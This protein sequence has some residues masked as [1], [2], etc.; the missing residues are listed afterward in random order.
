MGLGTVLADMHT[1]NQSL[2]TKDPENSVDISWLK[3]LLAP[4]KVERKKVPWP[5]SQNQGFVALQF[6][7][8]FVVYWIVDNSFNI[9]RKMKQVFC[10]VM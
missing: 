9:G 10:T 8:L 1:K 5:L 7:V 6:T 4:R 2:H 3:A